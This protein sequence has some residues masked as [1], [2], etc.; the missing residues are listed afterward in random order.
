[1]P[2][3]ASAAAVSTETDGGRWAIR[4]VSASKTAN[5]AIAP[6]LREGL[7][8]ADG[9]PNF[10]GSACPNTSSPTLY[11]VTPAPTSVTVPAKSF[12]GT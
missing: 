1:M 11:F 5:C 10:F 12:P 2:E 3:I 9:A 6:V 4:G 8:D 7:A